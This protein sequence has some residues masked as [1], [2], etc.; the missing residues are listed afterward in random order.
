MKWCRNNHLTLLS[1]F[2]FVLNLLPTSVYTVLHSSAWRGWLVVE[3]KRMLFPTNCKRTCKIFTNFY[4]Y[5]PL[6][7]SLYN[8]IQYTNRRYPCLFISSPFNTVHCFH[9]S[10]CVFH[11]MLPF[12]LTVSLL[13][14][15]ICIYICIYIYIHIFF[16]TFIIHFLRM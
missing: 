2:I 14:L 8:I 3:R 10:L 7:H 1:C 15:Y 6:V 13:S 11:S 5:S 9:P 4:Y 12:T 16:F